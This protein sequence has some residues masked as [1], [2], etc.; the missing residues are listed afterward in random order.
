VCNPDLTLH[1]LLFELLI[2][3]CNLAYRASQLDDVVRIDDGD[4]GRIV[5]TILQAT[6]TVD[7]DWHYISCGDRTD[8]STHTF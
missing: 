1:R 3:L 2:Q 4:P 8:N 7:E 6:Q 5:T